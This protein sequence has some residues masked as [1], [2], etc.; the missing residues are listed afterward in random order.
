MT[1][2]VEFDLSDYSSN[3][4]VWQI[5]QYFCQGNKK[6]AEHLISQKSDKSPKYKLLDAVGAFWHG[7]EDQFNYLINI[8]QNHLSERETG[9]FWWLKVEH[10]LQKDISG[11]ISS[12]SSQNWHSLALHLKTS[13]NR[14]F[15]S[16]LKSCQEIRTHLA[17]QNIDS[18]SLVIEGLKRR[19][20]EVDSD[21]KF[22]TAL[23]NYHYAQVNVVMTI[24]SKKEIVSALEKAI[25]LF[26]QSGN[27]YYLGLCYTEY[28]HLEESTNT[29]IKH[30]ETATELFQRIG[31]VT[32]SQAISLKL[33]RLKTKSMLNP[34][35]SGQY[36]FVSQKMRGILEQIELVVQ[37]VEHV[38][39]LGAT[40]TGK[41]VVAQSIHQLSGAKGPFISVNCASIPNDLIGAELFGH[42]KGSFTG[43]ISQK[44]GLF[45]QAH[46]GTLFLDEFGDISD[47][48]QTSLLRVMQ[49]GMIRR[50]GGKLDIKVQVRLI[51]A[52]N[53]NVRTTIRE[54]LLNR[55]VWK[56]SLA[57]LTQRQ[58]EILPLAE[59]FLRIKS[60][61][62]NFTLTAQAKRA[63]L[64][65]NYP[66]NIR[67]LLHTIIRAIANARQAKACLI[68]ENMLTEEDF[69][70]REEE[71]EPNYARYMETHERHF[72]V[73]ALKTSGGNKQE[74]AR[75]AGLSRAHFYRLIN[76]HGVIE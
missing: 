7:E 52:T 18:A 72:V 45:E 35:L 25:T 34:Q 38:L 67:D 44:Q 6:E 64:N 65:R 39:I 21:N 3:S 71:L 22:L 14:N 9:W 2:D 37:T 42:E 58:E 63:L 56:L 51:A 11:G 57:P 69:D 20:T 76:K 68:T 47:T 73:S 15:L 29:R 33:D 41:E 48:M 1:K 36:L 31:K 10:Q 43:S 13:H 60:D 54:D 32:L 40:G 8:A 66:G 46:G 62:T 19:F 26:H 17:D 30:L 75:K 49:D 61:G 59:H 23:T 27:L 50:I 55:F 24:S 28:A 4:A 5:Y 12:L 70:F 16:D 74:A 53:K